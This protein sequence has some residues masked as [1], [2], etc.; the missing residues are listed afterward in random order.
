MAL[1]KPWCFKIRKRFLPCE[2]GYVHVRTNNS[3]YRARGGRQFH[4]TDS[5]RIAR[6][7]AI[8]RPGKN[9]FRKR[10]ATEA[11]E[12][13]NPP[14]E[15]AAVRPERRTHGVEK[16]THRVRGRKRREEEPRGVAEIARR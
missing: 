12:E 11:P 2:A 3:F 6:I 1:K 14:P 8:I 5:N 4:T 10:P 13:P 9:C 15:N 7:I 16:S